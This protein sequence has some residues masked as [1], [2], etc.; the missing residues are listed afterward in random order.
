MRPHRTTNE[1][2]P[3]GIIRVKACLVEGSRNV[4]TYLVHYIIVGGQP[5][6]NRLLAFWATG[7][8]RIHFG[9]F[10]YVEQVGK[11]MEYV[12]MGF[13]LCE[14]CGIIEIGEVI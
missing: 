10:L 9:G 7:N 8:H 6:S 13:F 11:M 14:S 1:I 2:E 3:E 5:L 12:A 4:C